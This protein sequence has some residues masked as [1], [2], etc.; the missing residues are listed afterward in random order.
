MR[1]RNAETPTFSGSAGSAGKPAYV[2]VM[3]LVDRDGS[4]LKTLTK[5]V[6]GLFST[7]LQGATATEIDQLNDVSA[8]QESI[9]A[10]GVLSVTKVYSGL[11]LVGAGAVTLA[12]PSA[13]MLGQ[14]KT[15]EMVTDNGDVTLSLANVVG[16]TAATT[17]TFGSVRD[18]LVLLAAGSKWVVIKESGVVLS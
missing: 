9:L 15:I 3:E 2:E 5:G 7:D 8:Y 14:L 6:D 12:A 17:A 18:T 13:T 10:A 4:V 1:W 16:G 11:S